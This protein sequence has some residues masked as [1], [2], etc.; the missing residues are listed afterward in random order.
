M[1]NASD[2]QFVPY[3]ESLDSANWSKFL[4]GFNAYRARGGTRK[5]VDL[6][7]PLVL[8]L[9]RLRDKEA[10]KLDEDELLVRVSSF[11]SP[12]TTLEA[13]DRFKS[14]K[15]NPKGSLSV[16]SV[17]HYVARFEKEK[18]ACAKALPKDEQLKKLFVKG[19]QPERL[20]QR[21]KMLEPKNLEAAE[22]M[23][24]K[25][26]QLLVCIVAES[27]LV[28]SKPDSQI[29]AAPSAVKMKEEKREEKK[30][31]SSSVLGAVPAKPAKSDHSGLTCHNCGELGHIKPNC[32]K[33]KD[34]LLKEEKSWK[35]QDGR[36]VQVKDSKVNAVTNAG[37]SQ[38][39]LPKV[40]V[41]MIGLFGTLGFSALL[42]SGSEVSIINDEV[43]RQLEQLGVVSKAV[44]RV[45]SV[46]SGSKVQIGSQVT[47]MVGIAKEHSP[48]HRS[49]EFKC[50]F[51]VLSNSEE[52]IL[53]YPLLKDVG[54]TALLDSRPALEADTLV[55]LDEA[56]EVPYDVDTS[57]GGSI[58]IEEN[59]LRPQIQELCDEFQSL[60]DASDLTV[61]A[62]VT[63]MSIDLKGGSVLRAVPP[64][65]LSPANRAE[66][67]EQVDSLLANGIIRQSSSQYSSPIVLI[68]AAGKKPRLCVD[69]RALNAITVDLRYPM[70][71]TKDLLERMAGMHYF[72]VLDLKSGFHQFPLSPD[73]VSLTAFSTPDGLFEYLRI[74]FGLKNAPPFFQRTMNEVL[75]GLIGRVCECFV[76][77]TIVYGA[78]GS[79]F[80]SNLR[81]VFVRLSTRNIRLNASK[82]RL[83]LRK[84]A[85]LGH[86][87]DGDGVRLQQTKKDA[88]LQI[89]AP[90]STAE[91]R[92]FMGL[93]NY[94]RDF[95]DHFAT[96]S[97]PLY[98][99]C[100]EKVPFVWSTECNEA[101]LLLKQ[102]VVDAPLLAHV[103]YA[104][105]LVLR[106]DAST[107]GIG[108]VLL[109]KIDG[110]ERPVCFVSRAFNPTE[111]RWSTIE[112]EAF[113]MFYA[114]THLSHYLLGHAFAVETD[115]KNLLYISRSS[116]PKL[117]RWHLQLQDY[118]FTIR[119]IA[120]RDNVVADALSR[121][122]VVLSET[123]TGVEG[124]DAT[125][126]DNAQRLEE[127][128]AVHNCTVGHR[129]VKQT[130]NLLKQAGQSWANMEQDVQAFIAS[131]AT[132]QKVRK[133][134]G[135]VVAATRTISVEDVFET[136]SVDTVGPLPQDERGNQYILV[137]IDS[138]SRLAELF[139]MKST[140][141]VEAAEGLLW[142]VARYGAPKYVRSDQGSQFTANLVE[143]LIMK[144]GTHRKLAIAYRHESNGIVERANKE[145][146]RHLR[147]IIYD[148]RVSSDWS[149]YL[150][151]V[152]RI[153]NTTVSEATGCAPYRLIFGDRINLNRRLIVED[154][155]GTADKITVEDYV[156]GLNDAQK[157]LVD[158][159]VLHQSKVIEK[160]VAAGPVEDTKLEPGDLVL[161]SHAVRPPSKLAPI[162]K[163][164]YG[165]VEVRGSVAD[166]QDLCTHK[167]SEVH[168]SRLKRYNSERTENAVGEAEKDRDEY[169][170]ESIVEHSGKKKKEL[171]FRVRWVGY[172]VE[173]DSWLPY[174]DVKDL[175]ALDVYLKTHPELRL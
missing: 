139:P 51:L 134:R 64:R 101:F 113:A 127:L 98:Q 54:L 35:R 63:P 32:P 53:G 148:R 119:H 25:E 38:S 1:S 19:L 136:V 34:S 4:A 46:A 102:S 83:G 31:S 62:N 168:L 44:D 117:V 7:A 141:A 67:Q 155:S 132:C 114:I 171:K 41:K 6:M 135:N 120:G 45:V 118:D 151:L 115:H 105:P 170:V 140:K 8:T 42:D 146:L 116:T 69:F 85:Y 29:Y 167:I 76:D 163:G 156:Q 61:P 124:S 128:K 16:D 110:S 65:R 112:Q 17:L 104:Y 28:S 161:I 81:E 40:P 147:A 36:L 126:Q 89:R 86:E 87:V 73:V 149:A 129:G 157:V 91:L 174:S 59:D 172:G 107:K 109:Q 164:P 143:Q 75:G 68:R 24:I 166:V 173:D 43:A 48:S 93:A 22:E 90:T 52:V 111:S 142:L 3:L 9:V 88:L 160:R 103:D 72:A 78:D 57:M 175:E 82:C 108:A 39:E 71:N 14:L 56:C 153:L 74:P 123:T 12:G 138:F 95:I 70:N 18:V 37:G 145:V 11:F 152:Q 165:V 20:A 125:L 15:M 92:S 27:V 47:C 50:E 84:V 13:F 144:L 130:V 137:M 79:S 99:L 80:L 162:W 60:F 154:K 131:C 97:K 77:D 122:L 96:V 49:I 33:L 21:V 150:P 10:L 94:F 23:A 66:V 106:T 55:Q 158:A 5:A 159:S 30:E 133:E 121:C 100:S 2:L 169:A 58:I 26:V